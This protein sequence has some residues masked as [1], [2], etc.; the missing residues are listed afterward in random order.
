MHGQVYTPDWMRD[1]LL[2]N[3]LGKVAKYAKPHNKTKLE[4]QQ[5]HEFYLLAYYDEAVLYNTPYGVPGF[6]FREIG[7]LVTADLAR[8]PHPFDKV[9]LYSPLETAAKALQVWPVP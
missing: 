2:H 5:L 6:G 1:A 3:V 9:F 4:Q 7:A 8:N